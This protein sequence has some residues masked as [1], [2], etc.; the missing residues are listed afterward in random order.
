MLR[1]DDSEPKEQFLQHAPGNLGI[2]SLNAVDLR[3]WFLKEAKVDVPVL[4]ILGGAI[5]KD[6]LDFALDLL[7]IDVAPAKSPDFKPSSKPA[8]TSAP[9]P[10]RAKPR[11]LTQAVPSAPTTAP[12][13]KSTSIA[14]DNTNFSSLIHQGPQ[15][16]SQE[17][18]VLVKPTTN[19]ES[20]ETSPHSASSTT[21]DSSL[22]GSFSIINEL[23]SS[24]VSSKKGSGFD[25]VSKEKPH[26]QQI[27]RSENLSRGQSR[28]WF[29]QSYVDDPT[30]FN[31]TCLF[32]LQGVIDVAKFEQAV[33]SIG[34]R[35]E[36]LRTSIGD[37]IHG[38]L[39]QYILKD[40]NLYLETDTYVE[41]DDVQLKFDE[42]K[43]HTYDLAQGKLMRMV[44]LSPHQLSTMEYYLLVGYHHINM[45]GVSLEIILKELE[46]L[47]SGRS[48]DKPPFQF[49]D[50]AAYE[51]HKL[52]NGEWNQHLDYWK[53]RLNRGPDVFPILPF[54]EAGMRQAMRTYSHVKTS[55]V[56]DRDTKK[57]IQRACKEYKASPYHFYLAVYLTLLARW[58]KVP[59]VCIGSSYANRHD[60]RIQTS[61][62]QYLNPVSLR[63][64]YN[65]KKP[66]F[67]ALETARISTQEASMHSEVPFDVLLD[68]LKIERNPAFSPIFQTFINYRPRTDETR[69]FSSSCTLTGVEYESGKTPYDV[70]LDVFDSQ[71][72]E[73]R[74][75]I[76][77]Q[78]YLYSQDSVETLAKSYLTLVKAFARNPLQYLDSAPLHGDQDLRGVAELGKGK[79]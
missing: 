57:L 31:I 43:E 33:A 12:K 58:A 21:S 60:S 30:T 49:A 65:G 51:N 50:Y 46:D 69:P 68:H 8:A 44:L 35:H 48:L 24:S 55:L 18:P 71:L 39:E 14:A 36:A 41:K 27:Q 1:M 47:Y 56:I 19:I 61:V 10:A 7:P 79:L 23:T 67:S 40:A 78:E 72:D 4:R 5:L 32:K 25:I 62:G 59:E 16:T 22:G 17:P 26:T 70:M 29:L 2:D 34:R 63:L 38:T 75:E 64:A 52:S 20:S 76:S 6:L 28:F 66:F 13:S 15:P 74:V 9:T 73:S 77:L 53:T 3:T 37:Q 45:D 11:Q 54:G 42:L